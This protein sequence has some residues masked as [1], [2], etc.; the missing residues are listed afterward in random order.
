MKKTKKTKAIQEKILEIFGE[1]PDERNN[2]EDE[3]TEEQA[4]A[5]GY[6]YISENYVDPNYGH[7]NEY[8]IDPQYAYYNEQLFEQARQESI[9]QNQAEERARQMGQHIGSG[10]NVQGHDFQANFPI[11][12]SNKEVVIRDNFTN[13]GNETYKCKICNTEIKLRRNFPTFILHLISSTHIKD[14]K[15]E[16]RNDDEWQE[17]IKAAIEDKKESIL[18][19]YQEHGKSDSETDNGEAEEQTDND[20]IGNAYVENINP[21]YI[22]NAYPDYYG[23]AYSD[24]YGNPHPDYGHTDEYTYTAPQYGEEEE[25]QKARH[26]SIIQYQAEEQAR[27]M[28]LDIGQ[29]SA[30]IVEPARLRE[31]VF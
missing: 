16:G 22:E 13:I 9:I 24:Y 31:F 5:E 21:S 1:S 8:Y 25:F 20:N 3:Q 15:V 4:A 29:G 27:Q 10:S 26:D 12:S 2:E 23:N 18:N 30:P 6:G 19:Y 7:L 14:V 17:L 28:G 11:L